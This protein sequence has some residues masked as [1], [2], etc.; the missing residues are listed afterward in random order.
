[1]PKKFDKLTRP[2]MRSL[3]SG[4]RLMEHGIRYT[5]LPDGDG[6][7]EVDV[8]VDGKRIHR[9][10]GREADGVTRQQAELLIEQLRTDARHTRL[11]L[12]QNRKLALGFSKAAEEYLR[13]MEATDGKDMRAKQQKL[14][15]HLIPFF[16]DKPLDQ[17]TSFDL[18]RYKK[19]RLDSGRTSATVNRDLAVISHLFSMALEWG[20]IRGRPFKVNRLKEP[21]GRIIYLTTE[22]AQAVLEAARVASNPQIYLF[23]LIGLETGMRMS[24]I[25]SIEI[26]HI[27]LTR[28]E[29]YLPHTKTGTRTQPITDR[30][31]TYLREY[32]EWTPEGQKWVFPSIG[33]RKSKTGH[34][35]NLTEAFRDVVRRAGLDE[36]EI[37]RHTLRHTAITH[38]VQAGVD[39]PTVMDISGHKTLKMVQ[40]YSHR[41]SEH[42]RKAMSK[43]QDSYDSRKEK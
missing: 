37:V 25:L 38:L 34:T 42:I 16:G 33:T 22:Q 3:P 41:N 9:V 39:L 29:I 21:P 30:L 6:R 8:M 12:P 27:N 32:L 24:N 28:K 15:D 26:E 4:G 2:N 36:H 1:M 31:V 20:W 17:F 35:V 7:F 14:R 43:L 18:E 5:K 23:C 10:L 13:R 11:N 40:R 19:A